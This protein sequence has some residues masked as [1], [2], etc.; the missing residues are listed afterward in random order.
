MP[1]LTRRARAARNDFYARDARP[2]RG[3]TVLLSA[4][5]AA[6]LLFSAFSALASGA[7]LTSSSSQTAAGALPAANLPPTI[8]KQPVNAAVEE[9]QGAT[10]EATASGSPAPTVK[11]EKSINGG[12]SFTAVAG[13][14]SNVL[15]LSNLKT[16][17]SGRLYRA[18]FTNIAGKATTEVVTLTV[19]KAPAITGQPTSQTGIEGK[20]VFLTASASG[21]PE[22]TTQWEVSTD[23]GASWNAVA[24][25]TFSPFVISSAKL[26]Q[27][28]NEYR[29]VFTNALGTATSNAATLTVYGLPQITQLPQSVTVEEGQPATF[30]SA[31]TATPSPT[32]RWERSTDKGTTF[33][34]V[35]GAT[36][37]T[38]TIAAAK[39]TEDG[40][41]F[42]AAW[43]N[44]AGTVT[45]APATLTVHRAPAIVKQP[46]PSVANE[47]QAATF[48]ATAS[49]YPAPTV[50]WEVSTDSG[51][52]WA[53][54]PG[55]TSPVLT[56]PG[57]SF[58]QSGNL[59]RAVF[60]NVAGS[61]T[62]NSASLT[63]HSPPVITLQPASTIV[64]VGE[65]ATFESTATGFPSPTVQ[66][67]VSTNAGV[68]FSAIPGATSTQFTIAATT[69][70]QNKNEYRAVFT[71]VAA[72][73]SS[74]PATLTVATNHFAAVGWGKNTNLQLGN[75][76][77]QAY[78]ASPTA[79]SGLKFVTQIDAGARHSLAL[80]A[81]ET[82]LAW[83]SDEF[84]QLGEE[85]NQSS[86]PVLVKGLTGV[87]AV[88]AGA[89]HSLA[90]LSNGTVMAWGENEYG[91]LGD[92]GTKESS[93]PVPVKGLT[94]VTAI[95]AGAN[96][97]LALLS[98]GTVMAWGDNEVGQLGS[99]KASSSTVPVA[100]KGLKEVTAIS[101]GGDFALALLSDGTVESWG[102]NEFG[103]LGA[104]GNEE[105]SGS[106][107]PVPVASLTGVA[108]IAAGTHHAL[109]LLTGGTVMAWGENTYGE[110]GNGAMKA[111]QQ[112]PVAV[113]GLS[114]VSA[115]SAG[116]QDSVARLTSG[117]VMTWGINVWGTL[118]DGV[119]GAPSDVPVTVGGLSQAADVSAGGSHMLAYG[120]AI[121]TVTMVSPSSGPTTGG[122]T[123]T[124]TG[125]NLLGASAVKFGSAPAASFT[126]E[127]ASSIKAT[128]PAGTGTVDVTVTTESGTSPGGPADRFTYKLAPAVTKLSPV[129]GPASGGTSVTITGTELAGATTVSF[130]GT[131]AASFKVLSSTS[132]TAVAP[133][134]ASGYADVRV[135]GVG[136]TSAITLRDRFKYLPTVTSLT[137]NAGPTTGATSVTVEGSGFTPG[138]ETIFKFGKVKATSVNCTSSTTC[139][140]LSPASLP[141][142]VDVKA[143]VGKFTSLASPADLF[144]Y[145]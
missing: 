140:M 15:T 93:G 124:I 143:T 43:T 83:G 22:P 95:S 134:G 115:V 33:T 27:S 6:L 18:T 111:R 10:F 86:V 130:G 4:I 102:S 39:T 70:S 107:V 135:G 100:V 132:I 3:R 61:A 108:Q 64:Q 139:T 103:Q 75:G 42:R 97:S 23:A 133:A 12:T 66:W 90:L 8:T 20:P 5:A 25:A 67:E 96:F 49:G 76:G 54:V 112:T 48:E 34:V 73:L 89:E 46:G 113:S 21:T 145:S 41:E 71:N 1:R 99:G 62:S 125:L 69:L 119:I 142:A 88:A 137:P 31:G 131:P 122:A 101:A 40:N 56:L 81:N 63:V 116:G 136:G 123:V 105:E 32:V 92:G 38:L 53:E 109:A 51:G 117:G 129:S 127:S 2:S 114:G 80:I 87:K 91:Q 84:M 60:T 50:Q 59:Y 55:A 19:G 104:E 85:G 9:G 28:G 45:S 26:G 72:T 78:S 16:S 47:G 98:N 17:E 128:A 120:E 106:N 138:T 110:L 68:S 14:T 52:T 7:P 144:T 30:E 126:V 79:V 36:S 24:G 44:V 11:W 65:G 35:S 37:P 141:G 13:G 57:I 74:Q 118:G 29:A 82:V 121:P 77:N 58:P 94:G